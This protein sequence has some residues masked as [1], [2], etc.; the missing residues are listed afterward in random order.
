M[1]SNM[2]EKYGQVPPAAR[3]GLSFLTQRSPRL[4]YSNI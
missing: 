4:L 1:R 3:V 2:Q